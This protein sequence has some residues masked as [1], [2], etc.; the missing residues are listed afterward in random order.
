M[1]IPR[2]LPIVL[3]AAVVVG[4]FALVVVVNADSGNRFD[5]DDSGTIEWN[6]AK[7]ATQAYFDGT[8]PQS[9]A[10]DYW[11]HH[12]GDVPLPQAGPTTTPTPTPTAVVSTTTDPVSLLT[13]CRDRKSRTY[14]SPY[15]VTLSV[16]TQK[17]R[18]IEVAF[19]TSTVVPH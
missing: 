7:A 12:F 3:A 4:I 2:R 1:Y 14:E 15:T 11:L 16:V 10:V 6:E 5:L 18:H 8:L 17:A 9:E 13:G 19:I